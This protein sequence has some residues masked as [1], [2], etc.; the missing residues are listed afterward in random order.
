MESQ[1]KFLLGA[2]IGGLAGA[3]AGLLMAPKSGCELRNDIVDKYQEVSERA[4]DLAT[5]VSKKSRAMAKNVSCQTSDWTD[6]AKDVLDTVSTGIKS[7]SDSIKD[8]VKSRE[9][10]AHNRLEDV[11]E[12]ASLGIRLWNQFAKRR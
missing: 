12:W 10:E 2:I 4:Q 5:A 3:A 9:E 8:G 1:K 6:R 7:W 11:V